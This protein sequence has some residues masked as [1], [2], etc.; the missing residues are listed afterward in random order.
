LNE[1]YGEDT[2]ALSV[3]ERRAT[4]GELRRASK[5]VL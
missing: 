5:Q 4:W 1:K 3:E 2:N